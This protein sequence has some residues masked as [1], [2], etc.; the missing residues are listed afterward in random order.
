MGTTVENVE[1]GAHVAGGTHQGWGV[2]LHQVSAGLDRRRDT[3]SY[4]EFRAVCVA[5]RGGTDAELDA[6]GVAAYGA[7]WWGQA[8]GEGRRD[9]LREGHARF[10]PLGIPIP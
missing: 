10:V 5:A 9:S 1:T 7:E 4:G 8:I 2:R 6:A 3:G